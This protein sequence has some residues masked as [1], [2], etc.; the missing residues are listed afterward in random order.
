M[1]IAAWSEGLVNHPHLVAI[2]GS[3]AAVVCA[4]DHHTTCSI[5]V[6]GWER[7]SLRVPQL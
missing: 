1:N 5:A 2:S 6:A 4:P 3:P 7:A